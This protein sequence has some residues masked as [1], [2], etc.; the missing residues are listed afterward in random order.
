M[1]FE[2][3]QDIL[4]AIAHKNGI[5]KAA[6]VRYEFERDV[7]VAVPASIILS[8]QSYL[9]AAAARNH[10]ISVNV[11]ASSSILPAISAATSSAAASST[12]ARSAAAGLAA[13]ISVE[14]SRAAE[15]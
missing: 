2:R 4:E 5:F 12:A 14:T 8:Q 6:G 1:H 13:A 9:G 7:K 10:I 3:K 11:R 15:P